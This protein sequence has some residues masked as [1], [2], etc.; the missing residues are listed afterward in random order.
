MSGKRTL[1]PV[2]TSSSYS[3]STS[4]NHIHLNMTFK[5]ALIL[6]MRAARKC[7]YWHGK[8]THTCMGAHPEF[9]MK[10]DEFVIA[11]L[12]HQKWNLG[13]KNI[14]A[15]KNIPS[16]FVVKLSPQMFE[17]DVNSGWFFS[18]FFF[19]FFLPIAHA[20]LSI[21]TCACVSLYETFHTFSTDML[22]SNMTTYKRT[23]CSYL[24]FKNCSVAVLLL[25][26]QPKSK[27]QRT[28]NESKRHF[29]EKQ[30]IKIYS[31]WKPIVD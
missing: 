6:C 30:S 20:K 3:T 7:A 28:E 4:K 8:S 1:S 18:F 24:T 21:I 10:L 13:I 17:Q 27:R 9:I 15:S 19:F 2:G 11:P 16:T 22:R 23:V 12:L 25:L 5:K 14:I 31:N 29:Y 26:K